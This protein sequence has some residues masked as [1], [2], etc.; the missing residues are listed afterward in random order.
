MQVKQ[1]Y[2]IANELVK[3]GVGQSDV[4]LVDSNTLVD[5]G[6]TVL[7]SADDLDNYVRS[8]P[9]VIGKQIFVNRPYTVSVP[10]VLKDSWEY[11]SVLEKF[12]CEPF[13]AE[14]NARWDLQDGTSYDP[15]IFYKPVVE[16]KFFNSKNTY[17]IP[18]S[19]AYD[20]VKES[21][22]GEGEMN[23]FFSMIQT[24]IED[25]VAL[26]TERLTQTA[27]NGA[28]AEVL[29]NG[30]AVQK[31]N[32]LSEYNTEFADSLTADEAM[33][34]PEFIR[35]AIY[36]MGITKSRLAKMSTLFNIG[37][38]QRFTPEGRLNTV[39]LDEFAKACGVYLQNGNGQFKDEYISLPKADTV[40]YWQGSG[41]DY[42]FA[43][44]SKIDVKNKAGS[45]VAQTGILG[46]MLDEYAVMVCNEHRKTTSHYN[47]V[48]DFYSN[49]YMYDASYFC[50]TNENMVVF[51]IA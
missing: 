42:S 46:V 24:K 10:S 9:D 29:T 21:L 12:N 4:E 5:W 18:V 27:I 28:I 15:N 8:L 19:F 20:Q 50:D 48:G 31:I 41:T 44:T 32:L 43:S 6:K 37:G 17:R 49:F 13:E 25:A 22:L 45:E 38:K 33:H 1:I 34:S 23:R 14:E 51:Y 35:F 30:T 47:E 3:Q 26:R 11:G 39:L 40:A 36:K 2:S 7:N 16:V